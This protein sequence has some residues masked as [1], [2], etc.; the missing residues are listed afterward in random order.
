MMKI[1]KYSIV[2]IVL[3]SAAAAGFVSCGGSG[4]YLNQIAVTPANTTVALGTQPSQQQFT[5]SESLSDNSM[6]I[7][8][9]DVVTWA[10]SL[11]ITSMDATGLATLASSVGTATITATDT[12]NH[13]S[14]STTYTIAI[15]ATISVTPAN[16]FMAVVVYT[17]YQFAATAT[18]PGTTSTQDLT[19]L[20]TW[21]SSIP[22]V[23]SVT[24][25]GGLVATLS[26]GTTNI[27]AT[28]PSSPLG[29]T[30]L[31]VTL[32]ALQSLAIDQSS[33]QTLSLSVTPT[34]SFTVTG[35]DAAP[36]THNYTL[37][38]TWSSSNTAAATIDNTGKATAVAVGTTVI[39]ATDPITGIA[40]L[41]VTLNVT[42]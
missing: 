40:S 36:P 5:A 42:L 31:T 33:P 35:T 21:S 24:S 27:M 16:P 7:N 14:N 23:A 18:F 15:P 12:I 9:S 22:A 41:G 38:V 11:P 28:C 3:L 19:A 17:T 1:A 34:M 8:A 29:T 37:S 20:C 6:T 25:P 10:Y 32:T 4:S 2:L 26:P 30:Q 13:I 39:T